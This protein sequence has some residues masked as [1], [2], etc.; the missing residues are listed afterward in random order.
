[1]NY[2]EILKGRVA[3]YKCSGTTYSKGV[4]HLRWVWIDTTWS[5]LEAESDWFGFETLE[6]CIEDHRVHVEKLHAMR[7]GGTISQLL[8]LPEGE[9]ADE[10]RY[11]ARELRDQA[12]DLDPSLE[13]FELMHSAADLLEQRHPMPIPVSK[14]L[15]GPE[16]CDAGGKCWW[17]NPG[18]PAM[19]NPHIATSSWRLCR[20]LNGK[21]MGT[22]WTPANSLPLPNKG[23][24]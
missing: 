2:P 5:S 3:T 15:P 22:H 14:R 20:M 4:Y 11:L 7:H 18:Q 10:A 9:V 12:D 8:P 24:E 21:P 1:M 17:F 16:D 19:S 23:A 13:L 6:E